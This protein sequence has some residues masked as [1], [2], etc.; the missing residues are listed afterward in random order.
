MSDVSVGRH[1]EKCLNL[2]IQALIKEKKIENATDHYQEINSQFIFARDLRLAAQ[3]YLSDPETG[4]LAL[5]PR[6]DEI[7]VIYEDYSDTT[8][9]GEP[10]KKRDSL[11]FLLERA[12]SGNITPLQTVVKHVD[13][14]SFSLDAIRTV[15]V[16][17]DKFARIEGL[18]KKDNEQK[19]QPA[20]IN[21]TSEDDLALEFFNFIL[22]K[23]GW[24]KEKAM[25]AVK[26]EYPEVNEAKLLG[27]GK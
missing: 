16:V 9:T 18:Y 23:Y 14:R 7:I 20:V 11:S 27:D 15:D 5:I 1:A 8:P 13:I 22:E 10:K 17:L 2:E 4:D 21:Q 3:K 26:S 24:S 19:N 12:A 6:S 25:I